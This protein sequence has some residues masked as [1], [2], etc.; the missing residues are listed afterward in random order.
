MILQTKR[1]ILRPWDVSDAEQC[2]KYA[3]DPDVGSPAGWQ[4]H[5]SVQDSEMIIKSVLSKPETYAIVLKETG[6]PVGSIGLKF[7]SDL[8]DFDDE[9]ELGYWLGKPYWGQGIV[10]EAAKELIRHAFEDLN[11]EK[12][13]CGFYDGNE[14]SKRVQEKLGFKYMWTTENVPV[15]D[16]GEFRV[17]HVNCM[18]KKDWQIQRIKHFEDL[19]DQISGAVKKLDDALNEFETLS[20]QIKELSEYYE[21]SLW[22]KDF[23]DDEAGELPKELKRG[24]LSEDAVYDLLEEIKEIKEKTGCF[25]E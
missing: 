3:S 5:T 22:R 23:E 9:C 24:V 8:A 11:L 13:W 4:A 6:L 15:I 18:T 2:Y 7:H 25:S 16:L 12:I 14:K 20:P 17:G 10:P 19:L 1:L 21:S